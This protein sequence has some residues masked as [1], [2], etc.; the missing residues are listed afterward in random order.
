MGIYYW[1]S[2]NE[3]G[4]TLKDELLNCCKVSNIR[5]ATAFL[6]NE[7]VKILKEV[8]ERYT[9]NK[10][11]I[12]IYISPEF[13]VNEPHKILRQLQEICKVRIVYNYNLHAKVYYI[14]GGST[15][16]LI[17]GSSNLTNGGFI[18]NI[19]FDSISEVSDEEDNKINI[20]FN[21]C[22]NNSKELDNEII[23]FYENQSEIFKELE[24]NRKKF[25]K[26][27]KKLENSNDPFNEEDYDLID[28][29]FKFEDY[30]V[31]FDRNST[32][33]TIDINERRKIVQDKLLEINS[34]IYKEVKKLNIYHHWR[35]S[36]ITS[37]TIP[38]SY[39][40]GRVDWLGI[41]YG[42]SE[43]EVKRLNQGALKGEELGFQKHAC[44]QISINAHNFVVS[45]FHAVKNDAIDRGYLRENINKLKEEILDE[46]KKL[47]GQGYCWYIGDEYFDIDNMNTEKFIEFYKKN[48][49]EGKDSY[50]S[51]YF[52]PDSE[53]LKDK[54]S[55]S[56]YIIQEF[57]KLIPLYNL[58]T[59]R[60]K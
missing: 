46:L 16:K 60:F 45:L 15:K 20:F 40:N 2:K 31:F 26:E 32:L 55:L 4:I 54:D 5:I 27:F 6:S 58:I 24:I 19:E 1:H 14:K 17:F 18:K 56:K 35:P 44:L 48:D 47:K 11:N 7:G 12:E 28:Q 33:D 22:N 23:E 10:N 53:V 51:R 34:Q 8:K 42:K 59:L 57:N 29:Y 37:L 50:I 43:P 21:Y 49:E 30:E 39:N 41:R 3:K 9:L 52:K 38:C 13:S 36:N 25:K